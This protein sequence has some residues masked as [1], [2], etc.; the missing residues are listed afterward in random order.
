V[1]LYSSRRLWRPEC[2]R[3]GRS[4]LLVWQ[5]LHLP[6][7]HT[8]PVALFARHSVSVFLHCS[9]ISLGR[10]GEFRVALGGCQTKNP[11]VMGV[12][13]WTNYGN[14]A[15]WKSLR[16]EIFEQLITVVIKRS[17]LRTS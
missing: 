5:Q 17:G 4:A 14:Q 6:P 13:R 9:L 12:I 8:L 15:P 11:L 16:E 1:E 7:C 10:G 2:C 3:A